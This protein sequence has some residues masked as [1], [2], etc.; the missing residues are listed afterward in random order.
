M[1]RRENND[2][3][4]E[5]VIIHVPRDISHKSAPLDPRVVPASIKI[6]GATSPSLNGNGKKSHTSR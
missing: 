2:N 1:G 3:H 4:N 5:K 6:T